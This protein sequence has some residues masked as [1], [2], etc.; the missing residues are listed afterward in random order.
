MY[1]IYCGA[2]SEEEVCE[3]CKVQATWLYDMLGLKI[4]GF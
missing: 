4:W 3:D 2:E 1:C